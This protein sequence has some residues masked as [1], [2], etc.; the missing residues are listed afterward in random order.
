M[1]CFNC[2]FCTFLCAKLCAHFYSI[3]CQI[4]E[5]NFNHD[6]LFGSPLVLYTS[7]D[8]TLIGSRSRCCGSAV[9]GK[10][11]IAMNDLSPKE[12]DVGEGPGQFDANLEVE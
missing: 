5:E 9:E 4:P 3:P 10:S 2:S 1:H 8:G 11:L 6:L 12:T 7:S